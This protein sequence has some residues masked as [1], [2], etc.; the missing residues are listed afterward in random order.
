MNINILITLKEVKHLTPNE[1]AFI[2]YIIKTVRAFTLP[3]ANVSEVWYNSKVYIIRK[4]L[5]C[6]LFLLFKGNTI[7]R[8]VSSRVY[9]AS[10]VQISNRVFYHQNFTILW[11]QVLKAVFFTRTHIGL[12]DCTSPR[13]MT[14]TGSSLFASFFQVF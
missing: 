5:S 6:C 10:S 11:R 12:S 2:I 7:E 1:S 13:W 14:I 8:Y 3:D 4:Q 9:I